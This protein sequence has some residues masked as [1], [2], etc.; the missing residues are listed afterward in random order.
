VSNADDS[1]ALKLDDQ[2]CVPLYV[3]T[4]LVTQAYR[5]LLERLGLTYPQFVVMMVLWESD[6][7][8]VRE[9]GERLSLDSGTL[10]PVLKR[11]VAAELIMQERT[12]DDA[13]SLRNYVAP[14][15]RALRSEAARIPG[16]LVCAVDL[17][18]DELVQLREQLKQLIGKLQRHLTVDD[19]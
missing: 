6:G 18:M 3:A 7:A 1:D 19:E 2:L 5:P 10:T 9:I 13:R 14:R 16:E 11:L 17:P 8:S 12:S 4:R 15:G